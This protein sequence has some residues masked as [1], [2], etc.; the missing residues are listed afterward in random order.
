[1]RLGNTVDSEKFQQLIGTAT[2][3]VDFDLALVVHARIKLFPLSINYVQ[4]NGVYT[5]M[6]LILWCS[7]TTAQ[8]KVNI[9]NT[10]NTVSLLLSPA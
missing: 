5:Y 6:L 9:M 2:A 8:F 4:E 10:D 7:I 3:S 1:M